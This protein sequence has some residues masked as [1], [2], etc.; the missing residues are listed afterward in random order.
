[1]N[2]QRYSQPIPARVLPALAVEVLTQ[3]ARDAFGISDP[4]KRARLIDSAIGLVQT[5]YPQFFKE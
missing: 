1:M 4:A 2:T 3:A 5:K